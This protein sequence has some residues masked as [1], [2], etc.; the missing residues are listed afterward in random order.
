MFRAL[1]ALSW[2]IAT[3]MMSE[4]LLGLVDT[5]L[6]GGLGASALGG[7][8]VAV[9]LMSLNYSLVFGAMRAPPA[10][11]VELWRGTCAR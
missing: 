11:V 3:G 7:V 8:G 9:T 5:K 10:Y 6:V 1:V 2:P 4:T